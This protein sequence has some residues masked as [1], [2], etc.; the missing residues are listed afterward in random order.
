[1][2][3]GTVLYLTTPSDIDNF[4]LAGEEFINTIKDRLKERK[5]QNL[6]TAVSMIK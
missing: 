4:K 3:P 2:E 1:V 5:A 6:R